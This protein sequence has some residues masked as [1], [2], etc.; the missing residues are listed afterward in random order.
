ML[1]PSLILSSSSIRLLGT[2]TNPPP[3]PPRFFSLCVYKTGVGGVGAK[4]VYLHPTLGTQG[5]LNCI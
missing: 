5:H 3:P 1:F 4:V 2:P